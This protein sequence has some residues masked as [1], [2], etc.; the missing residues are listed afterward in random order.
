VEAL[1]FLGGPWDGR[2][3]DSEVV[4]APLQV[5]PD[6]NAAGTYVRVERDISTGTATYIWS[7][8]AADAD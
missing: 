7:A 6:P 5:K 4:P 3:V 8:E 1:H 2:T